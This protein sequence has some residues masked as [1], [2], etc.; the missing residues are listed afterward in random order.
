M[1]QA[2]QNQDSSLIFNKTEDARKE[3]IK[4]I[5][6]FL[7]ILAMLAFTT[8]INTFLEQI[9]QPSSLV[10][11]YLV[12]TITAAIFFGSW[13]S[14]ITFTFGFIIFDVGFVEPY[15][16]LYIS[17]PQDIY[18]VTVYFTIAALVT[19]L[20]NL[21]L[22]QNSFLKYK[23][24]RMSLIEDMSRDF[25]YLT[26]VENPSP[27]WNLL[28]S[29]KPRVL[30]QLG[31]L[32]LKYA[33]MILN[34][35]ALVFFREADGSLKIWAQSSLNLNITASEHTAATWTLNN[36]EASGAGTHTYPDNPYFFIPMKSSVDTI[37]VLAIMYNSKDIYPEQHRLLGTICNL[38]TIIAV[39]W[40]GL[41]FK[42]D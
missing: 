5:R 39:M 35:P 2:D 40:M 27:D 15:Y 14:V 28:K 21:V 33:K 1:P 19:Y 23:L 42:E 41:K 7:I 18:N 34:V 26:P 37:G 38:T 32:A 3:T 25:L 31:Q 17:K 16:T 13:A 6:K 30:S 8:V 22:R 29:L 10:F 36:G 20:I 4:D 9:I 11:V 24:D 12:P